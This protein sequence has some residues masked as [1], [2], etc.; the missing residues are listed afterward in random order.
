M[1]IRDKKGS[2]NFVSNHLSRLENEKVNNTSKEIQENFPNEQLMIV[3]GSCRGM[4]IM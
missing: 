2:E 1:E 3:E 4:P